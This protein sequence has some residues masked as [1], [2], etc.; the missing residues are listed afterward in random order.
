[1]KRDLN[2]PQGPRE[3][4]TGQTSDTSQPEIKSEREGGDDALENS[5]PSDANS[6]EKVIVNEQKGNKT[7]NAPSQTAANTSES[8]EIINN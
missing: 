1:M 6:D 4:N 5:S 8:G 3:K 2:T 7:V